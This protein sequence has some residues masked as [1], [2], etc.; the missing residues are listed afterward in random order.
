MSHSVLYGACST[1]PPRWSDVQLASIG[2]LWK[3]LLRGDLCPVS[4]EVDAAIERLVPGQA[5][6]EV[7]TESLARRWCRLRRTDAVVP[8]ERFDDEVAGGAKLER[9]VW[10]TI[11]RHAGGRLAPFVHPQPYFSSLATG[12]PDDRRADFIICV[13]GMAPLIWEVHGNFDS[14]DRFKSQSLRQKFTVFDQVANSGGANSAREAALA[15]LVGLLRDDED[16][17][18]E[19]SESF[20]IEAAWIASQIDLAL[21]F[22][23]A[24][25]IWNSRHARVRVEVPEKYR[26]IADAAIGSWHELSN[27]VGKIY[28]LSND[29]ILAWGLTAATNEPAPDLRIDIDPTAPT[30]FNANA[31]LSPNAYYIRRACFPVDVQETTF[32]LKSESTAKPIA[33]NPQHLEVL[34]RRIFGRDSFRS[35]QV[36][37]IEKAIKG[38]DA[39]ILLPTGHGKSLTFQLASFLT[40]GLVVIVEPF[41]A[42]IDDQERALFRHGISKVIALHRERR[43]PAAELSARLGA[44]QFVYVAAE[45][46]HVRDFIEAFTAAIRERGLGLFVV[47]EAHTVSQFGHSF[48]P[49]YLDLVERLES[50]CSAAGRSRPNTIALTATAARRVLQDIRALLKIKS[51]PVALNAPLSFARKNQVD[52]IHDLPRENVEQAVEEQLSKLVKT[53]QGIV[54]CPSKGKLY[55]P[56]ANRGAVLGASGIQ[57]VLQKAGIKVGLYVGGSDGQAPEAIQRMADDARAFAEGRLQIMVGTSAFGTGIDIQGVRWTVHVGMPGGLDAYYQE[58][59]RAGRSGDLAQSILLVDRDSRDLEHHLVKAGQQEDPLAYLQGIM[60]ALHLRGSVSRQLSLLIGTMLMPDGELDLH[61]PLLDKKGKEIFRPSFPGWRWEAKQVDRHVTRALV[62]A[63]AAGG[64]LKFECHT[65]W[66]ELVWKAFHRLAL[67]GVIR[68]GFMHAMKTTE[69]IVSFSADIVANPSAWTDSGL[70]Q[71]VEIEVRRIANEERAVKASAELA[72]ALDVDLATKLYRA[73]AILIKSVYRL[74][75]ETRVESLRSLD[76]YAAEPDL[77]RRRNILEDYFSP[78]E[79]RTKVYRLSE[80][81]CTAD[82]IMEAIQLFDEEAAPRSAIFESAAAEYPA[83]VIPKLFLALASLRPEGARE[84]AGYLAGVLAESS[85]AA[86]LR[87]ECFA[88]VLNR[89]SD[90]KHRRAILDELDAVLTGDVLVEVCGDMLLHLKDDDGDSGLAARLVAAYLRIRKG[91]VGG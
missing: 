63:R 35:S 82:L 8:L 47:D 34:L 2:S 18:L 33:P 71:Q 83:S 10:D 76:R 28:G 25:G 27:A 4:R 75:F 7:S 5:L 48:R 9:V 17:S 86:E 51:E 68:H 55:K 62:A 40:P 67:L 6:D 61:R 78:S 36:E 88:K 80:R 19:D 77:N 29:E 43:I 65:Y 11:Q 74:V 73:S 70:V 32:P 21:T 42:L 72:S 56:V 87:A 54:F 16:A 12:K 84:G 37:A 45:R 20:L 79:I 85:V 26:P 3:I 31:N 59:G 49:A 64:S 91:G 13:P 89:A 52:V 1:D 50:I 69:G 66:Q 57:E 14:N 15:R 22:L 58:S 24:R 23:S 38:E 39:L 46:M 90:V 81:A 53:G 44:A 30:Y 60:P 41:R